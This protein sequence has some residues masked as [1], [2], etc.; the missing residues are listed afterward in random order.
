MR[1]PKK[2]LRGLKFKLQ[3]HQYLY[4]VKASPVISD[5]EYDK[6]ERRLKREHDGDELWVG[7]PIGSDRAD[8]YPADVRHDAEEIYRFQ[9]DLVHE[10]SVRMHMRDPCPELWTVGDRFTCRYSGEVFVV[11]G[12]TFRGCWMHRDP[13]D[14]GWFEATMRCPYTMNRFTPDPRAATVDLWRWRL[15]V[16]GS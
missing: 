7:L 11:G 2:Q 5:A 14:G 15:N 4:Y 6:L 8:D 3:V 12:L 13:D 1:N 10:Q 9:R 16:R